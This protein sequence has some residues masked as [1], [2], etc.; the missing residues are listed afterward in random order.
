MILCI[1]TATPVCS[2]ALCDHNKVVNV[3]VAE[4]GLSHASQLTVL[5][6]ELLATAGI[7]PLSL[8]AVAVS[9]GPGSYTGLRIGV[10]VAKGIAYGAGIPLIGI[11]T[12][13][14]MCHGYLAVNTLPRRG[15]NT[16]V[17]HD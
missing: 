6:G 1:E 16:P 13:A 11:N 2:A 9:K 5:I 14:A 3:L 12:L 15:Y 7:A 8:E 4:Q 17:P 10:S